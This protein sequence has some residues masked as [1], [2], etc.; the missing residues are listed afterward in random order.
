MAVAEN[1]GAKIGSSGQNSN[2]GGVVSADSNE[3]EKLKTRSDQN[4]DGVLNHQHQNGVP[5][6]ISVSNSNYNYNAQMGQMLANGVQNQQLVVNN[7]GYGTNGVGNGEN[8]NE[9]FKR[10]MRDLEELLSKLNPM[11]EEFVP[12][13]ATSLTNNHGY[14][15]GPGAGFGYANN[16]MLHDN[17]GNDNGQTNR[18]R[19]NGYNP[20][21]RRV[22]NKMDVEN[23]EEMIRRTVYVS[24]IDQLVTE[25]QLAGL[26]LNCGQVV[27]CRVCG[28]PNSILRFAFIEFTDEESANAALNL[29]G[30]MLGYY[31]L[32]VLPSKTAI[33]PVNPTFLPRSEDEREMCS[34]TI[35]CTNIDKKLTQADVKHFFECICGE[36]QRLRLLGD[37]HHSTRIAFVEFTMAESAIAALSCSGVVLGSLPIRVSP[38]KTPV[39]SRAPRTSMP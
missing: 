7:E 30:T 17:Y 25:E 38:S 34:R 37:Y 8:G 3:V 26:F 12:T 19:K 21:K 39:R 11:A 9:S 2:S 27:D 31:P 22:N 16:F 33:A 10:E 29:S 23:R 28:D 6:N 32:R 35:Y 5:S 24:D 18:R 36:V 14:L 20:G 13:W 4:L 1:G 15:A